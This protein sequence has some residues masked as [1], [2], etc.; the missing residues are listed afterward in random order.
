MKFLIDWD[1][2]TLYDGAKRG[3]YV[4]K[5][6]KTLHEMIDESKMIVECLKN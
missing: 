4:I 3:K 6:I 1:V 5:D 2:V